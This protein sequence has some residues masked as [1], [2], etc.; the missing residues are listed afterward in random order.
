MVAVRN[1][2]KIQQK[3][4]SMICLGLDLDPKKMPSEYTGSIKGMFDFAHRIIDATADQVCAYK[5][6]MAFYESLGADGW[7]LLK[8]IAERIPEDIPVIIDGK[9][10]DIGNTAKAYARSL[11][12]HFGAHAVTLSPYLGRESVL[13]FLEWKDRLLWQ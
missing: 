4:D 2:Q 10:G 13:P 6:N 11:F 8:L 3:N 5:P 7:S 1:L 9:R 12:G